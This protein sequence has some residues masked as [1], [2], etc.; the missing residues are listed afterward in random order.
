MPDYMVLLYTPE[1]DEDERQ[2]DRRAEMPLWNELT[3]NLR[4]AGLLVA[5]GPLHPVTTATTVRVRDGAT[6][7][8]D[9]PFAT[10]KEVLAGFYVLRCADLD[11]ALRHAARMPTARNGSVEVRP[12]VDVSEIPA[13]G[14]A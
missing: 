7:L 11:E 8:T 3:R 9:G 5:H 12:M 10:T 1:I 4:D 2:E 14:R 6:E 13:T